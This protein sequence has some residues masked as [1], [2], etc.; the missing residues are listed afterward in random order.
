MP[1]NL[2][3]TCIAASFTLPIAVL[4]YFVVTNINYDI[5]FTDL[6]LAGNRY[7]RPLES[8]LDDVE[9]H[10]QAVRAGRPDAKQIAGRVAAAVER[11][12]EVDRRDG[13][14]LQFTPE[15]LAKRNR[16]DFTA[17][18][19]RQQWQGVEAATS[20]ETPAA[21]LDK[22]YDELTLAIR[23]MIAHAGDTSNLILDPDLDSYYLM[24]VT[25]LALP[26][27][28]DR[29][30]QIVRYGKD[31][32]AAGQLSAEDRVQFAVYAAML[33]EADVARVQASTETCLNEDNNFF[34]ASPTLA[35]K[36]KPALAGYLA[37]SK[38]F[39][40]ELRLLAQQ[41]RPSVDV[42]T[43]A[44][45]GAKARVA[46]FQL[47]NVAVDELDVL[48]GARRGSHR[49]SLNMTL[50]GSGIAWA[51]AAGIAFAV[52]RSVTRPLTAVAESLGPGADLLANCVNQ[53]AES[54][55]SADIICEELSA[56]IGYLRRAVRD[57]NVIVRGTA[58][59]EKVAR[60]ANVRKPELA[61]VGAD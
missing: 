6:E 46:S 44:A 48:L 18:R 33:E 39:V 43:F 30:G 32:L 8:L 49:A 9:Q 4:L 28:Q 12:V 61:E 52:I 7:Q 37:D 29:L 47:W 14:E 11:L 55:E 15:G 59:A 27:S 10:R 1:L 56:H 21:D 16:Q 58:P 25:L 20:K 26:Q 17:S 45:A 3:V 42:A 35:S 13:V 40:A 50:I 57:L 19:V 23:G 24:D 31:K 36:I 34:G 53:I 60:K 22:Q 38:A 54:P 5:R 2:R 51:I 41:E